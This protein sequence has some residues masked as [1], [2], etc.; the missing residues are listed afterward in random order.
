MSAHRM[1]IDEAKDRV[2]IPN[3]W[4][5][6]N[7]PGKP[8]KSCRCPWREDRKPSFSVSEDG[9][10]FYDFGSGEGGDAVD[11]LEK[12][13]RVDSGAA[14]RMILDFAGAAPPSSPAHRPAKLPKVKPN[15]PTFDHGTE[16]DISALSELRGIRPA[17]LQWAGER[18]VLRFCTSERFQVRAWVVTDAEEVNAQARRLDGQPWEHLNGSKAWTLPGSWANWPIGLR[19]AQSFPA[20]ALCEGG[21]DFLAAHYLALREQVSH[22]SLRDTKCAPVAMLGAGLR[23][24]DDALRLFR[25]KRVRIFGHDDEAGKMGVRKWA[26]QLATVGVRASAFDCSGLIR[27]DRK[28]AKDLNDCLRL[29][30]AGFAEL[31]EEVMPL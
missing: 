31:G 3:L 4:E 24:H 18:G 28:P 15:F 22:P 2:T 19:E 12:V 29:N 11:F 26:E 16:A 10:L 21:P 17:G 25:G 7:L 30:S 14:C 1:T 6:F 9:R 5:R 20:I 13:A 8:A 27:D 23:I